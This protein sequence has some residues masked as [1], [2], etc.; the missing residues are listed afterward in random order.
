[1]PYDGLDI[2][3]KEMPKDL[4]W[5]RTEIV[6]VS[7]DW[8]NPCG[9]VLLSIGG[10]FGHYFQYSTND[11]YGYATYID[12][13]GSYQRYLR[14]NKKT[15]LKRKHL[16]I[17]NPQKA[18]ERLK[19]LMNN[20]W[21]YLLVAHNC[22]TFVIEVVQAGGNFWEFPVAC[23]RPGMEMRMWMDKTFGKVTGVPSYGN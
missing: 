18:E 5:S 20:K 10:G 9:H 6:L 15:E 13:E 17:P 8:W 11:V 21:L 4:D 14:E 12:S 19:G 7:G 16:T 2:H 1:M 23:P 3:G 22:V